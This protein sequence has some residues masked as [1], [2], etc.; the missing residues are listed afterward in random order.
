MNND[1]FKMINRV[2]EIQ[3]ATAPFNNL[4]AKFYGP[5][6]TAMKINSY[7]P[8]GTEAA[9][10]KVFRN[11]T[12]IAA[13]DYWRDIIHTKTVRGI[14][15]FNSP[16][17]NLTDSILSNQHNISAAI[18]K[19][20]SIADAY[21]AATYNYPAVT[22]IRSFFETTFLSQY[23]NKLITLDAA[24]KG[25]SAQITVKGHLFSD[26]ELLEQ[27]SETT[28]KAAIITA[29]LIEKN[30]VTREDIEKLK[31]FIEEQFQEIG[32]RIEEN[33]ERT[34]KSPFAKLSL[35][36]G[37]IGIIFT[38]WQILQPLISPNL[39][40]EN[41]ATQEDIQN[42]M[43]FTNKRLEESLS[44]AG[45]KAEARIANHL[46]LKPNSKSKCLFCIKPGETV[47]I[48]ESNHKWVR[49]TVIDPSDN[50][51]LTGWVMR[52]HLIRK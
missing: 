2:N 34:A 39:A 30:Y 46:R 36:V 15:M 45:I 43:E 26:D 13:V 35:W 42:L 21:R 49:V 44:I 6:A 7:L 12:H 38:I 51:P 31:V 50:L 25:L 41:A 52:K 11:A 28:G 14:A 4:N 19:R 1:F 18:T 5:I 24:L 40:D 9:I 20:V 3:K 48:I 23:S 32:K 33:I 47:H 22:G 17:W 29:E 27:F 37:I 8:S 10:S 16:L